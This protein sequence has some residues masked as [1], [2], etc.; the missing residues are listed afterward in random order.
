MKTLNLADELTSF[1]F[2]NYDYKLGVQ[3]DTSLK[4]NNF[5]SLCKNKTEKEQIFLFNNFLRQKLLEKPNT[6]ELREWLAEDT[7]I[8]N[9]IS[10]L[11]STVL[12][13][14]LT[15]LFV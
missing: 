14:I 10:V 13:N 15:R 4:D 2:N 1:I 12:S 5:F 6:T 11:H 7:S 9:Y 8:K 3:L